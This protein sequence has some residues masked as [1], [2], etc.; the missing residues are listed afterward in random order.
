MQIRWIRNLLAS[1][2]RTRI[3]NYVLIDPEPDQYIDSSYLYKI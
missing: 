2:I 3:R 1:W